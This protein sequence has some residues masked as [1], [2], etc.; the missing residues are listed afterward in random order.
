MVDKFQNF[1]I[2]NSKFLAAKTRAYKGMR[3]FLL[4]GVII[5]FVL[6]YS[7]IKFRACILKRRKYSN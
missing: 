1:E 7:L 2:T 4:K 6:E 5:G 3:R